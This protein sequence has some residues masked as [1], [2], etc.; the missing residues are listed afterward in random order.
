MRYQDQVVR[1]TQ[2]AL[3]DICRA[4]TAIPAD[5]LDWAPAGNARSALNQMQEIATSATW[6]LPLVESGVV[7]V[8]DKEMADNHTRFRKTLA[9]LDECVVEARQS[10]GQ[11]C[12][13][14]ISFADEELEHEVTLPFG[15]GKTTMADVLQMH[16]WNMVYHLGQIN[17][18]QLMLGDSA[19][20]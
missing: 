1:L 10:T 2:K 20:H 6:F 15:A 16:Y 7:P 3:D 8:F 12:Q 17:Q 11:L 19:M 14:I 4:A 13:A 18:I 9:R 5:K